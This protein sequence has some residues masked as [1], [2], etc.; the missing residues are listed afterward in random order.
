MKILAFFISFLC[1]LSNIFAT[2]P[3]YGQLKI[4]GRFLTDSQGNPVQ[5]RGLSLFTSDYISNFNNEETVYQVKCAWN[6]NVIRAPQAPS[7]SCCGGWDKTKDRDFERMAAVINGAIKHGI[8]VIIDWHA[9]GDPSL[10]LA[11]DFFANMSK[12]FG[13]K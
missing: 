13:G 8:Y 4:S 1:I 3:P 2:D 6:G 9:F 11:K 12:S 5:L 10:D 7:T